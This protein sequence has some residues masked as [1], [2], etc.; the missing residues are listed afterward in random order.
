[1][2]T[3]LMAQF[4]LVAL[5]LALT[6]GADWAYAIS[7]G[8]RARSVVP[9]V[10]GM[11]SGYALVVTIVAVGAG[12][13]VTAY[14]VTLTAL[15]VIGS[16]YLLYLGVSTLTAQAPPITASDQPLGTGPLSQFVRGAGIS[17]INPKGL[18]LLLALLP[19]FTSASGAWSS[20]AQMFTLGSL[21]VANCAVIYL[22]VALLAR[23]L[24]GSRPRASNA[25][26]KVSGVLMV[27]IGTGILVEQGIALF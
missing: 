12:A 11:A 2:D 26:V 10:A 19:Q 17:G 8:L 25:V 3:A 24:L 5:L 27:L 23:Q 4:W 15:T 9:S 21:H 7:A 13:V 22:G 1:M 16:M 18:L 14:P 6:P 20:T